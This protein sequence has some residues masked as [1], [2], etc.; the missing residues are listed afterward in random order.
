MKTMREHLEGLPEPYRS[1]ALANMELM[2]PEDAGK[3][4][5]SLIV[6]L[7][8]AFWWSSSSEGY[9]YWFALYEQIAGTCK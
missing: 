5:P 3:A 9:D 6:A 1:Q 8:Y 4:Y 7:N 2:A